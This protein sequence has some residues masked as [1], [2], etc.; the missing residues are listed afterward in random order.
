MM[1]KRLLLRGTP[2]LM[3]TCLLLWHLFMLTCLGQELVYEQSTMGGRTVTPT[4]WV[5]AIYRDGILRLLE[6]MNLSH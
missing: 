5:K 3:S 6:P 1:Q 2:P 4:A